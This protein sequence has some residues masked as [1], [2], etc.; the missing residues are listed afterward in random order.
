MHIEEPAIRNF[1]SVDLQSQLPL[2]KTSNS[3]QLL[4]SLQ[5]AL[6]NTGLGLW[7]W[8]LISSELDFDSCSQHILSYK[9]DEI[10]NR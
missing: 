5:I 2:R 6:S 3:K 7:E 1:L 4:T 8:N 10:N 9:P